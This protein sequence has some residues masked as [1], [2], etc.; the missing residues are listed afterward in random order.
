[1]KDLVSS[2]FKDS[3]KSL[4]FQERHLEP[5]SMQ[6]T[7][8]EYASMDFSETNAAFVDFISPL[9]PQGAR[10]ADMGCGPGEI[11]VLL[12]QKRPDLS[13]IGVDLADSMLRLGAK[14]AGEHGVANIEWRR[15]DITSD[16][17]DEGELDFVYSHTTLHH[18][19]DLKPFFTTKKRALKPSGGFALRDLRRPATPELA[20][21]WIQ[22]ASGDT[23]T[24]RQYEL[25]FYSL[26]AS[27]TLE[28]M[29]AL[30]REVQSDG[31]LEVFQ[32]PDRYWIL[33]RAAR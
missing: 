32:N 12:A 19:P 2:E 31:T 9:I 24:K 25:F 20:M 14:R 11:T 5:E 15:D 10:V 22:R 8:D 18:V 23:L 6:E 33:Y 1:M 17:F 7:A 29:R 3:L 27:L 28:E 16:V 30:V 26:R 4:S 13:L 21:E